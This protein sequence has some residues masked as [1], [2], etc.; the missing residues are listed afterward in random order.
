[1]KLKH[2]TGILFLFTAHLLFAQN[3][4][5]VEKQLNEAF[6]RINYWSSEGRNHKNFY[7]SLSSEN[8]HTLNYFQYVVITRN[9]KAL[10]PVH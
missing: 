1:M 2:I 10:T 4:S 3:I 5:T 6:Q 7:D 8:T 9:S